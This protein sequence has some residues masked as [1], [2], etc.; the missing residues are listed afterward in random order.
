M[1]IWI[2]LCYFYGLFRRSA[3]RNDGKRDLNDK[4]YGLLRRKRL[5]TTESTIVCENSPCEQSG[6]FVIS[7]FAINGLFCCQNS[8][9]LWKEILF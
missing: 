1:Y 2:I 5:A 6:N 8:L 4:R 9:Q 7:F 3:P